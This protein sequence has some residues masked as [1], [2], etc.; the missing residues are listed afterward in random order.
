MRVRVLL[1]R[2]RGLLGMLVVLLLLGAAAS[3]VGPAL[4]ATGFGDLVRLG[5]GT[6]VD[7]VVASRM[8]TRSAANQP[9]SPVSTAA[10]APDMISVP[11]PAV[12]PVRAADLDHATVPPSTVVS[13]FNCAR[14]RLGLPPY[15]ADAQLTAEATT[16]AARVQAGGR[17][18]QSGE[19]GWTLTGTLV[20]DATAVPQDCAIGG[21][22]VG[23]VPN[24]DHA[25]HI[26]I[27]VVP[28]PE[29]QLVL[30]VVVG[31]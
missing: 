27:A 25:A 20:L 4:Q 19:R 26:G 8:A 30:A 22:D 6:A 11:N 3:L 13:A 2:Q 23:T 9:T 21:V 1:Y 5:S 10:I 31:R 16:V 18:P 17:G 24:L 28:L 15:I 14:Q 12:L 29:P 7:A